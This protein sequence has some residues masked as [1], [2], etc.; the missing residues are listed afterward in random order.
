M[1]PVQFRFITPTG[2]PVANTAVQIQLSRSG[3]DDE[4]TGIVMPRLV[5]VNTDEDG[6]GVVELWPSTSVYH[7]EVMDGNS[8]VGL[9]YKFYVPAMDDPE[10]TVR[11]QDIVIDSEISP[12]P[13]DEAAILIIQNAKANAM[14]AQA[15]AAA[16]AVTATAQAAASALSAAASLASE[17]A[18]GASED[19]SAA[20]QAA[21]LASQNAASTSAAAALA[22]QNAA[23]ISEA[24]ADTSEAAALVSKNAAAASAT[25]AAAS[26]ATAL[27]TLAVFD[28]VPPA[29]PLPGRRWTSS[30]TG[31]TYEWIV[32]ADSGQW[33]ESGGPSL[34]SATAIGAALAASTGAAQVGT[35]AGTVQSDLNARPTTAAL[36][37]ADGSAGIG[38]SLGVTG[39]VARNMLA[40]GRDN[41]N[42]R[43][44]GALCDGTSR[45]LSTLY[46]SLVAAQ[47]DYPSAAALTDELDSVAIQKCFDAV[48]SGTRVEIRGNP[49]S[50]KTLYLSTD[51]VTIDAKGATILARSGMRFSLFVCTAA[52]NRTLSGAAW[53]A[54]L[55]EIPYEGTTTVK[56]VRVEGWFVKS[57][58]GARVATQA[59]FFFADNCYFDGEVQNSDGSGVEFRQCVKPQF[60]RIRVSDTAG[61]AVFA[62]Q[63][64]AMNGAVLNVSDVGAA[65]ISKQRHKFYETIDHHVDTVIVQDATGVAAGE[66]FGGAFSFNDV[67]R[68]GGS[69][70]AI[71]NRNFT[72]H[73]VCKNLTIRVFRAVVTSGASGSVH[74]PSFKIGAYADNWQIGELWLYANGRALSGAN[75]L[76]IGAIGDITEGLAGSA[77]FG[78]N[79]IIGKV[80]FDGYLNTDSTS[81]ILYGVSC[82]VQSS[83]YR[84]CDTARILQQN[85]AA[86]LPFSGA[87]GRLEFRNAVGSLTMPMGALAQRGVWTEPETLQFIS[88]GCK[89]TI[90]PKNSAAESVI[91]PWYIKSPYW[92]TVDRDEITIVDGG[93]GASNHVSSY[94]MATIAASGDVRVKTTLF[95]PT[96]AFGLSLLS[97]SSTRALVVRPGEFVLTN[98]PATAKTALSVSGE[99]SNLGGHTYTGTWGTTLSDTTGGKNAQAL[100]RTVYLTAAPTTGT[101]STGDRCIN[102]APAVGNPKAWACTAAGTP[103]TWVSEGNL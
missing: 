47:A 29:S 62:Y 39:S 61:Y 90:T 81:L 66:W 17:V 86:L 28:D 40:K 37:A 71:A 63:C 7:V 46:G 12:V 2:E 97:A 91:N 99:V 68:A 27:S 78:Q 31:K 34:V 26:E 24:N 64:Y 51:E 95:A 76:N 49:V 101:W 48:A 92:A 93:V 70:A 38:Y 41:V 11:L 82:T 32:D 80:V 53:T 67:V 52:M 56:N 89:L 85:T 96:N 50:N 88:G 35:T 9:H 23:A 20:S 16:S 54:Q 44:F 6:A 21:A 98:T 42:V 103:G 3:F 94:A 5:V 77:T 30:L 60:G 13:Y 65:F 15:G 25:N 1:T 45:P 102:I 69:A 14:A 43:D 79:H 8:E 83:A 100:R 33:V 22:S 57:M 4:A 59:A 55:E 58:T 84:N 19:A 10:E 87:V 74:A 36:A 72:G 75:A 18:A 73:E